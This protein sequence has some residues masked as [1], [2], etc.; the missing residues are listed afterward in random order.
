MDKDQVTGAVE[1]VAGK[2]QE[3]AGKLVG[4]KEEQIRGL[5]NKAF[6][7]TQNSDAHARRLISDAIER[8]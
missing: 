4:S 7:R 3:Q 1:D 2:V 6:G 5:G 8:S